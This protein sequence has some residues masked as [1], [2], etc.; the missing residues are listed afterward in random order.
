M[1]WLLDG[2]KSLK[3][4]YLYSFWQTVR[5]W[6]TDR[7]TDTA[8]WHRPRLH[9]IARQKPLVLVLVNSVLNCHQIN[10]QMTVK[11]C[12]HHFQELV[13]LCVYMWTVC[14]ENIHC[15]KPRY[16]VLLQID[17]VLLKAL[18]ERFG[19]L[20]YFVPSPSGDQIFV[21]FVRAE[22]AMQAHRTLT[23]G[24]PGGLPPLVMEFISDV[25]LMRS[26][27]Q[28]GVMP[29]VA[30]LPDYTGNQSADSGWASGA[31]GGGSGG[32]VWS[33][34]GGVEDHSSFLPSDLFSGGQ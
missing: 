13:H 16:P 31:F 23:A 30:R 8:W 7:R 9:S 3:I 25:D 17:H 4:L 12:H 15:N 11:R 2:E 33:S 34:G 18:L 14:N 26:L 27:D 24:A 5:T 21:S 10:I 29:A 6:Q 19:S 28:T 32:S 22:D 20:R 1:V